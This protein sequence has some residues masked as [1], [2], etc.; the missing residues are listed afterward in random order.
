MGVALSDGFAVAVKGKVPAV[1]AVIVAALVPKVAVNV[2]WVGFCVAVIVAVDV[3][4][5]CVCV[6]AL[7]AV[8]TTG[9]LLGASE[10]VGIDWTV[11]ST[12]TATVA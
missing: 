3:G 8:I 6:G 12:C 1:P 5:S 4:G 7:V 10:G 11:C 2:D 9:V